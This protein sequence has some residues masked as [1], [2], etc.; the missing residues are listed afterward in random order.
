MAQAKRKS[1][2]KPKAAAPANAFD[3]AV[4]SEALARALLSLEPGLCNLDRMARLCMYLGSDT[5]IADNEEE[6]LAIC[7]E[8]MAEMADEFKKS[9]TRCMTRRGS[10]GHERQRYIIPRNDRPKTRLRRFIGGHANTWART[11]PSTSRPGTPMAK[12]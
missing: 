2:T 9:T 10:D 1:D 4:Q 7:L 6:F 11:L 3:N 12:P 5:T 8:R